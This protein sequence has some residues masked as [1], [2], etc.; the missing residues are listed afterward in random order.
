MT[1]PTSAV[2]A[3]RAG[4]THPISREAMALMDVFDLL[5]AVNSKTPE[6]HNGRPWKTRSSVVGRSAADVMALLR[7]DKTTA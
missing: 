1:D 3:A 6:Q 4:W 7:P 2:A 5:Y